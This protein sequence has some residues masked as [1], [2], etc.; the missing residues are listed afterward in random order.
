MTLDAVSNQS[1]LPLQEVDVSA[2]VERR[3]TPEEASKVDLSSIGKLRETD[4]KL[5]KALIEG[6][7]QS[8]IAQASREE[9]KR[10]ARAKQAQQV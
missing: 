7:G 5:F 4:E 2:V 8:I 10:R 6:I 1:L 3:P 9:A